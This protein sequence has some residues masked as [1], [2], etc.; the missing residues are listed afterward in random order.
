V[1]AGIEVAQAYVTIIPSMKG[2]QKTIADELDADVIGKKAGDDIGAGIG[3]GLSAKS[4]VIGN[5][6]TDAIRSAV[7][8]AIDVG[9]ELA[10]GVYEGYASNEQLVGG[11]Q[12]LFGDNAQTVIDNANAAW[13]TAGRSA[14]EY[15]EGVTGI[16][17][18]LVKSVG[19]DTEEAARLANVAM[20][21]MSDNVNTFGTDAANVQNAV[22]GLAKGNYSMLDNLSLGFAGTQ[23]G[24]VDLINASGVLDHQLTDTKDLANVGFGTMVEAI[25]AVQ[26]NM[27]IAGT[28]AKEAMGTL[29]GSAT[30][31]SAA[32]QNVLTSIGSG[33]PAQVKAA[34]SGLVDAI[35][36]A[37]DSET[38]KREGGLIPNIVALAQRSFDALAQALPGM[39]DSA[40]SALPPD[41][42][43]PLREAFEAIGTVVTTVAPIVTTAISGI[44]TAVGAIAPVVAPLLPIIA[45]ALGAVK[46]A[47]VITTIVGAVGGF[48][49]AAGTAIGMIGS[50]PGLIA[51]VTTALGGPITIIAAIVGAIVAFLATNEEARAKVVE[52]WNAIKDGISNAVEGAIQ[53]VA[54]AWDSLKS[55]V[56]TTMA[57]IQTT[58]GT[59]WN[60][61]KTMAVEKAKDMVTGIVH[62]IQGLR[63]RVSS[64]FNGVKTAIMTPVNAARDAVRGAIDRIKSIIN[65]AHLSLPHFA[66][67]HFRINGGKLPWGIGGKGT[68]PSIN[69]DW[70]ARGGWID[71][72]TL[73]AG[74]GERG[75]E[76]VWPSYAPYLDRYADALAAR[77]GGTGGVTV[78]LTYNGSGDADELVRTLTRDLRMMRM[79]GAI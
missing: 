30:A 56:T 51:V 76:F 74:V 21:A 75:G 53:F 14:N 62:G 19:G 18:S 45:S 15:M 40:L 49:T 17:A 2:S 48:I 35:F 58:V 29:E 33:D 39:L 10:A 72:P 36:G 78:N 47:G 34:A 4:V 52:V 9:K 3:A 66:L 44:V 13:L 67:P 20:V 22:M 42:G 43:G 70:Y 54:G 24:M 65:G 79:T 27:G 63:A 5:I 12:K 31:A 73:L 77:M 64:V 59:V 38:G 23:Q 16:A 50:L 7:G 68:P 71:N 55:S 28:T 8:K 69:V 25:Q 32:W 6:I 11:M 41:V 1:A 26:E 37:I 61:I 46:I 60:G 57:S